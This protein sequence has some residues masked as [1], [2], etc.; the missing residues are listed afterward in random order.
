M[1]RRLNLI[2]ERFDKLLVIAFVESR[3]RNRWWLCLC[4]CGQEIVKQAG[5]LTRLRSG[6]YIGCRAC[7]RQSRSDSNTQHGGCKYGQSRLYRCWSDMKDRCRRPKRVDWKYYGGKG[8]TVFPAWQSFDNFR[9]WALEHGY[10]DH[11]TI[12]RIDSDGNYE[13]RNCRW[14][15]KSENS[16][17]R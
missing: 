4:D 3:G 10:E 7:E 5:Q 2:G 12:D 9:A 11:L 13:P 16:R 1:G 6:D 15:T 17:V 14:I 8:I